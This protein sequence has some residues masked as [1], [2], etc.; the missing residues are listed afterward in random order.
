MTPAA[1]DSVRTA[2]HDL[3]AWLDRSGPTGYDPYDILGDARF[4][5][6]THDRQGRTRTTTI[7]RALMSARHRWPVAT[8]RA[9]GVRPAV[10]AKGVGLM[11]AARVRMERLGIPG[12]LEAAREHAAWLAYNPSRAGFPGT[13]WGYPFDW[14]TRITV[15]AG[16]PSAVVTATCGQGLLDLFERAADDRAG[17]AARGAAVFLAEGLNRTEFDDGSVCLSYTPLDDFQVHN[18][19]LMAAE[20]LLRA[21]RVFG[22]SAWEELA[23]ACMR[24]SVSFQAEDGSFEYWAPD[25]MSSSQIDNYHTGFVLRSLSAFADAGIPGSAD[26]L[27]H[28]WR[29]YEQ[30]FLSAE[31]KPRNDISRDDR[32]DIHSCAESI[33]CP[34]VLSGRFHDALPFARAAAEWTVANLRNADGSFAYG[35]WGDRIR[36]MP[37]LRWGQAWMLRALAELLVREAVAA[38][39]ARPIDRER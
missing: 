24:F 29:Y 27:G 1:T 30:A 19:N 39:S 7:A 28:G 21:G 9:F 25:Q 3:T 11:V 12:S 32:L 33:L 13:S 4:H 31:G 38:S 15:P 36:S 22:E 37:Y 17:E 35:I 10:N 34:A 8:R 26:A 2:L 18:A 16:T 6:L 23:A 20:Y 14:Y 5:A